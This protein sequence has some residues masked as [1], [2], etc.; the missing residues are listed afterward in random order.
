MILQTVSL[1]QFAPEKPQVYVLTTS[2]LLMI[3]MIVTP[4]MFYKSVSAKGAR[5]I[6][7]YNDAMLTIDT[8]I[9]AGYFGLNVYFLNAE[10][11]YSKPF[12]ATGTLAWP[13]FC[14]MMRL[15]SLGRLV[16]V[17]R[18]GGHSVRQIGRTS[19]PTLVP[20]RLYNSCLCDWFAKKKLV[21]VY[22]G[23]CVVGLF[24]FIQL[25]A[26]VTSI[27]SI[28]TKCSLE[29]VP[30]LW[31]GA[32]P[33]H[34]FRNGI[35][36]ESECAYDSIVE[37]VAIGKG[38]SRISPFIGRCTMLKTLDVRNNAIATLPRSLLTMKSIQR[39]RL[40]GNPVEHRL[41]AANLSLSGYIFCSIYIII[42]GDDSE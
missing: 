28:N 2:I 18:I 35:F 13:V 34:T 8:V 6:S 41:V 38:I 4:W 16:T 31:E 12:I 27:A 9:D 19:M 37:I 14:V 11:L 23:F 1:H 36:G 3:N 30:E 33:K 17:Q 29:L 21:F 7:F 40:E 10:D 42:I 24:T 5:L 26:T 22:A 20:G 32:F 39:A 15:R 25:V